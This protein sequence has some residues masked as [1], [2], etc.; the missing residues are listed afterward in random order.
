M[1]TPRESRAALKL[2][3]TEAVTTSL[4]LLTRLNGSPEVRRAALLDGIPGLIDH[5]SDGSAT[6]AADFYDEEREIAGVTSRFTSTAVVEDRTVK[7]RRAVAWSAEPLILDPND[8]LA[9]SAR[10]AEVVQLETARPYRDT[11]LTNRA[12]DPAAAGWRRITAGGCKLCRMLADRGAV[13]REATA[14]FA[15]H[16]NCHCT[17]QPVFKTDVGEEASVMQYKASRKNRTA[18][19]RAHLRDYLDTYY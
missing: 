1:P 7:I 3:T 18:A 12:N 5:Y 8:V 9:A 14:R 6:L 4:D 11:I 10:L 15:T 13:Y 16:T 2:L 19:Q 17:A